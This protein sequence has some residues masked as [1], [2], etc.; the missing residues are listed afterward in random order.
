MR[1][2]FYAGHLTNILIPPFD[3]SIYAL[4][5][6]ESDNKGEFIVL[7]YLKKGGENPQVYQKYFRLAE[8][9]M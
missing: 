1:Y 9:Y 2:M 5:N 4:Q 8:Q 7:K 6:Y 3:F